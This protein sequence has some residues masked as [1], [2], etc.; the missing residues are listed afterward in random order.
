M[1]SLAVVASGAAPKTDSRPPGTLEMIDRLRRIDQQMD[2]R[3]NPYESA[4]RVVFY[5]ALINAE[6]DP[7]ARLDLMRQQAI[8]LMNAGESVAAVERFE[9]IEQEEVRLGGS[10]EQD[11]RTTQILKAMSWLRLGEQ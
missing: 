11:L 2:L 7:L 6:M 9:E 1:L 3:V 10:L 4:R 8:E 5:Q